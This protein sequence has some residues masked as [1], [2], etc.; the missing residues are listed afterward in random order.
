MIEVRLI[1]DGGSEVPVEG[2]EHGVLA[3]HLEAQGDPPADSPAG[4]WRGVERIVHREEVR[5][6]LPGTLADYSSGSLD[7]LATA[8]TGNVNG[9]KQHPDGWYEV[10]EVND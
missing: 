2:R 7:G 10:E 6:R 8:I 1:P 4:G 3:T 5:L 9:L